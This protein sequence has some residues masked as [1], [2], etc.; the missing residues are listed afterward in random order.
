MAATSRLLTIDPAALILVG[1]GLSGCALLTGCGP[2]NPRPAS[3]P[4]VISISPRPNS[5][6]ARPDKG[7]TVRAADGR[8]TKVTVYAGRNRVAG[9]F[10]S[11]HAVWHTDWPLRP[12]TE[13]AVSV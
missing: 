2:T 13:Y 7:L 12:G 5:V 10:D 11:A 9:T 1:C 4:P 6:R 8:L 3:E